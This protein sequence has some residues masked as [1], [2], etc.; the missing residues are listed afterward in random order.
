MEIIYWPLFVCLLIYALII[1]QLSGEFLFIYLFLANINI[2]V[3]I[4][5]N[6]LN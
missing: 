4:A 5:I 2:C 1:C 6:S 3:L